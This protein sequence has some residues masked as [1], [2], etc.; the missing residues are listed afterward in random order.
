MIQKVSISKIRI[1]GDTQPRESIDV[2]V[3]DDY[4][5]A[6]RDGA[7]FP[8]VTLF[9]DGVDHWLADG[10]HRTHGARKA[11]LEEVDAE[12]INGTK[13]EAQLYSCGVN[14]DHGLR[15]T[16]A[17]KRKAVMTLLADDEWSQWS[18]REIARRCGVSHRLVSNMRSEIV[19]VNDSQSEPQPRT[20]TTRH[21]TTATMSTEN[22]GKGKARDS[23]VNE[24]VESGTEKPSDTETIRKRIESFAGIMLMLFPKKRAAIAR[25]MKQIAAH[26][27]QEKL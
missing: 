12:V 2:N 16:N 22:I 27:E 13:R 1:D 15:R 21:G 8:P 26:I 25:T 4:A 5:E 23:Q 24:T 7:S 18:D 3:V 10:F 6:M 20:Y 14:S 17:D 9:F 19:T 11:G